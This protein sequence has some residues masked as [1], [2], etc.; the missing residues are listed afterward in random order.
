MG[1]NNNGQEKSIYK[2]L[3][4]RRTNEKLEVSEVYGM[5]RE[6]VYNC[7]DGGREIQR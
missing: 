4:E 7:I 1:R 5:Q 2:N 3:R 6:K